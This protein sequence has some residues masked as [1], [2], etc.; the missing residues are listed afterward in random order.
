M[1]PERPTPAG[2]TDW[3]QVRQRLA[4]AAA[5]EGTSRLSPEQARAVLE[6]RARA[7]ARVPDE[8]PAAG[9]VVEVVTFELGGECYAVEARL[10][11]EVV[12]LADCTPV[13]GAPEHLLGVAN[14]RGAV[15][16]VF[17]L[18]P[19]LGVAADAPPDL[20]RVLV[21]GDGQAELGAPADVVREV[22]RLRLDELH[23]PPPSAA[24]GGLVRG[25]T[26]GA[27]VVLDGAALLRDG[28]LFVEVAEEGAA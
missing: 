21:L 6:E 26:A 10:V 7:L 8:V 1:R 3:G 13:P 18:R 25:V 27:V 14:L 2:A 19:L 23:P 28:R 12:R 4:R 17:D 22:T 16:A 9:D 15:L 24:G 5:E 11:R 20:G